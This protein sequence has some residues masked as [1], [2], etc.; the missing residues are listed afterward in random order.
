MGG[1]VM[2]AALNMRD[3]GR[4]R[5][6]NE[7]MADFCGLPQFSNCGSE[8]EAN[9]HVKNGG[10]LPFFRS[11]PVAA[12]TPFRGECGATAAAE[13]WGSGIDGKLEAGK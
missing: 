7:K 10:F 11:A 3:C 5:Q 8:T 9:R 12:L 13:K 6:N 1:S 4:L 2:V